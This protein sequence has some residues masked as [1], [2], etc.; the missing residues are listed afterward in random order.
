MSY[1]PKSPIAC[2]AVTLSIASHIRSNK[3]L[4]TNGTSCSLKSRTPATKVSRNVFE[5]NGRRGSIKEFA[6]LYGLSPACVQSRLRYGIPLDQP[7][8]RAG[9][10]AA[11][12]A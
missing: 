5:F 6:A 7:K 10:P 2:A 9:R 3:P 11:A 12:V 1:L 8:S 4:T